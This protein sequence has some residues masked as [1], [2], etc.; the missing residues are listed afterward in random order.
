[1]WAM[2]AVDSMLNKTQVPTE[3]RPQDT[4]ASR[5]AAGK[6][7]RNRPWGAAHA[8]DA[9]RCTT[10]AALGQLNKKGGGGRT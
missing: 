3:S 6:L 4:W 9:K 7:A 2:K 5:G 1:M 8:P 10:K